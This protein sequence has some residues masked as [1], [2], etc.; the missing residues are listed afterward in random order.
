[1]PMHLS[2]L[3]DIE[4]VI[5][6][7][8]MHRAWLRVRDNRGAAGGDGISLKRFERMLE[9]NLLE[10][11]DQVRDGTYHPSPVRTVTLHGPRKSR[12]IAILS[13][14]DRVLQ[15]AVLDL[16]DDYCD[17]QFLSCSHAY[18]PGRSLQDAVERIV[19]LRNS[20]RTTVVDADIRDCFGSLNHALLHHVI[21]KM[22]PG[23]Q[24][25]IGNLLSAWIAMTPRPQLGSWPRPARRGILQ[26][27]PISPLLCNMYLHQMDIRL[28]SKKYPLVRYADDFVIPCT[29]MDDATRCMK[30]VHHIL[31]HI[32]LELHP[33]K[34]RITTF[35]QGLDFL[36]VRFTEDDYSYVV[37]DKRIVVRDTPPEW[38]NYHA[39]QYDA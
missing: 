19:D 7:S 9:A 16:V 12:R 1:M 5:S 27:A 23:L 39:D 2:P 22:L 4:R 20:G 17:S 8:A 33:T 35:E 34:T 26:G 31:A 32:H 10:L 24:A 15:R 29:T 18:R 37:S 3:A 11:S 13:V 21:E 6:F 14:R 38:F 36:G 30:D 28:I 25:T